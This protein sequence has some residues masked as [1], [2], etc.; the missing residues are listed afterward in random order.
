MTKIAF[1]GLGAMGTRMATR[2]TQAGHDVTVWNRTPARTAPLVQ[3]GAA[4]AATP[5][6]AA[7]G[8]EIVITMLTDD[9]A[10]RAVWLGP[11]GA[12]AG[13]SPGALAVEAS[14][15]SPGW[16]TDLANAAATANLRFLDAPVAGSLP[17]A[18]AGALLFLG[19][20]AADDITRFTPVAHAMGKA[21]VH[22][23]PN[24]Q[25]IVL[26]MMVNALLAV[27]TAAMAELLAYGAAQGLDPAVAVEMLTPVPVTSPAAAFVAGQIANK[28]HDPMFPIDLLVKDLGY[29]L[30]DTPAPV[31]ASVRDAFRAAQSRGLGDRHISAI[32]A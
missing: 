23:G 11:E 5:A 28:E 30:N 22:A 17:Q 7:T 14:T 24:G 12:M 18:E 20:G 9:D 32:A 4:S 29:L 1:L 19:G 15:V 3:A 31:M 27:Q 13:M 26:K 16:I 10:A 8:A 6:E 2:L 21:I 25:G